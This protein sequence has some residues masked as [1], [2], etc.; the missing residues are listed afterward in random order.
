AVPGAPPAPVRAGSAA[1][2]SSASCRHAGSSSSSSFAIR[3]PRP[4]AVRPDRI[5]TGRGLHDLPSAPGTPPLGLGVAY[6]TPTARFGQSVQP[7]YGGLPLPAG[8]QAQQ[9]GLRT[10]RFVD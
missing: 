2:A 4:N 10:P 8:L 9:R 1:S 7:G 6:H 5:G 3:A